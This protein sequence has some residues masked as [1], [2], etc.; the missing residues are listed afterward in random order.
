M[1]RSHPCNEQGKSI[2][3]RGNSRQSIEFRTRLELSGSRKSPLY[4]EQK[5]EG[6]M[7]EMWWK[8]EAEAKNRRL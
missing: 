1:K 8:P 5:G 6:A 4:L 2:S 7:H 3:D